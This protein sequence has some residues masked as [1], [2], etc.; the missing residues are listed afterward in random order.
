YFNLTG[1]ANGQTGTLLAGTLN[2]LDFS[3]AQGSAAGSFNTGLGAN[4]N[5]TGGLL[6]GLFSSGG[7][8]LNL[9]VH[10]PCG[11]N[12]AGLSGT[13]RSLISALAGRGAGGVSPAPE[14]STLALAGTGLLVLGLGL[15]LRRPHPD[16]STV[17]VLSA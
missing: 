15:R 12:I 10:F 4:L 9:D 3:Q 2:L 8:V 14:P 13:F 17:R 7:G 5:L 16:H 6:A 11:G 1:T